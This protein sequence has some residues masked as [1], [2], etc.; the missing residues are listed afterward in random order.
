MLSIL[1]PGLLLVA[2]MAWASTRIKRRAS[3]AFEEETIEN[4]LFTIKKPEG[5]LHVLND[6]SGKAFRG[7]SRE[8]ATVNGKDIKQATIEIEVYRD[9]SLEDLVKT[10]KQ[11]SESISEKNAYLDGGEKAMSL[12][13]VRIDGEG[14][15]QDKFKLVTRGNDIIAARTSI[16]TDNL[17]DHSGKLEAMLDH[18]YIK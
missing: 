1:I 9:Y 15:F 8:T 10:I 4:D 16:L 3:E 11:K 5:Y 17:E 7:Y 12:T 18:L 6:D 2:F 14:E 13:A